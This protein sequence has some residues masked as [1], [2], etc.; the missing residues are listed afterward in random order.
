[1]AQK[2]LVADAHPQGF[3]PILDWLQR[4]DYEITRLTRSE[5]VLPT[6]EQ[7][8]PDLI[9]LSTAMP[10]IDGIELCRRLRRHNALVQ[11]PIIL[12]APS[13]AAEIHA[14]GI[15]AGANDVISKPVQ[16]S[17]ISD[18]QQRVNALLVSPASTMTN[19]NRLLEETCQSALAILNCNLAW[20][21][22]AEGGM[23]RSRA[24]VS[25]HGVSAAEV[26]LRLVNSGAVGQ[27]TFPLL[28]GDNPLSA[29]A[30][31]AAPL[32][33]VAVQQV[34]GMVNGMALYRAL[35]QL[36][37]TYVH[38]LVLTS[39]GQM[40]GLL[41][42]GCTSEHDTTSA[43][44]QRL[45]TALINQ[46]G[47]VIENVR[48]V[49]YLAIHEE[50]L[51]TEQAFRSMVLDTMADGL[52]VVDQQTIIRFVNNRLLMMSGY[53]Y[54]ELYGNSVGVIFHPEGRDMLLE[55]LGRPGRTTVSF[56]QQLITKRGSIIPVLMSRAV[57][58]QSRS[59]EPQM[60]LVLSDLT[61]QRRREQALE[62][63]SEQLRMLNR[64]VQTIT[65]ALSLEDVIE[66]V[67]QATFEIVKC[68]NAC[69]FIQSEVQP[70]V[71]HVIAAKGPQAETLRTA[72]ARVGQG[73]VGQ[74][75]ESRTPIFTPY[76]AT[77]PGSE[78]SIERQGSAVIAIPLVVMDEVIGVLEV[79]NKAEGHFSEDDAKILENLASAASAAIENA[80]LYGQS[81]RRVTELS[82]M[83]D[84]SGAVSS[85]LDIGSVLE[86][87]ARR[88]ADA[89]S[90]NRCS[91]ATW[92][93][94]AN[95]LITLAETCNAYWLPGD[96][97]ERQITGTALATAVLQRE[98][99]SIA[100]VNDAGLEPRMREVFARSGMCHAMIIPLSVGATVVG[101][102]EL[103]NVQEDRPFTPQQAQ[104][105]KEAIAH[106]RGQL[107]RSHVWY[108]YE[109]LTDLYRL[110]EQVSHASWCIISGWDRRDKRIRALREVGFAVWEERSGVPY[111]LD[112]YPTMSTSLQQGLPMTLIPA[113]LFNDP[114]T[115]ALMAGLGVHTGLIIPLLVRG[116]SSGLVQLL[117]IAQDRNFDIA[118]ITLCQGIANVVGNALENARLYQSL[119]KRANAL[120]AAYNEVRETDK[121][122]DNLIQNLSHELKTPLQQ[123]IFELALL[124]EGDF[125]P[126]N[127]DQKNNVDSVMNRIAQLG[128]RVNQMV[129][130][131]AAQEM[132]FS[133]VELGSVIAQVLE[134]GQAKAARARMRI[135]PY[136]PPELP[137]VR[138]D[139]DR[140]I[141]VIEQ[142]LDNAI[143]FS[144]NADRIELRIGSGS[145]VVM[146][147]ISIRDFGIGIDRTEFDKIFQRGY[148]VDSGLTRRFGGAGMG[149]AIAKQIIE[150]HG[151]KIWV[152]SIPGT[153]SQFFFTIPR[154]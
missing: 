137:R 50:R 66:M 45:L 24:I 144:P 31:G 76:I 112:A 54:Q 129:S 30:L 6:A 5:Q 48:L 95:R 125:G 132:Q 71:L 81:Q 153:G 42:L 115:Q 127:E 47:T 46:A 38:F 63:Q 117:D 43:R 126:L 13:N 70:D 118:E 1:M 36:R 141:E 82:M 20:L 86:L 93:Q 7:L 138:A 98:Q 152:E 16:P 105:V 135:V 91:I 10:G 90:V 77:I 49:N 136:L 72:T 100:R 15:L 80:R 109:N 103:Y 88:L 27:P 4:E 85:T 2:I 35:A 134:Q 11:T 14:E 143:K 40:T 96:G 29:V 19:S 106:W 59:V 101:T 52:V 149:L 94:T 130:L 139:K 122:K 150:A 87:I 37:L 53:S 116:E 151:G 26:F 8:G 97:P 131:Q 104:L 146:A 60:V 3:E 99:V 74:V 9:L 142:I 108:E 51:R 84:A 121:V 113:L 65:S 32:V 124:S 68:V 107:L 123:I 28:P 140:L 39:S 12:I 111:R 64:A 92:D 56:S 133:P 110:V 114:D 148:Q 73:I 44:G 128:K 57:A 145:S 21:M 69:I 23:L 102:V 120:Q 78:L 89:M 17:Q 61:E 18:I 22:I 67:L 34:Q 58:P 79:I 83:L 41:L 147:Q 25:E 119:E 33:N 62:S 75:I 154:M 55:S